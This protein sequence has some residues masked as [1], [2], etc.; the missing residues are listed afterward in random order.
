MLPV[1]AMLVDFDGTAC[2]HDAAEHLLV[3][4]AAPSW[5]ELDTAWE[6]G[7]LDSRRVISGQGAMLNAPLERLIAFALEHCP[8]DPTFPPFVRWLQGE[9]VPVT[10]V[11]DGFGFY[12]QP[13]L[14]A[15]GIEGIEVITNTWS[16]DGE[17]RI[18]FENGHA[19][20]IGCGTCKM[21]AVL[22]KPGPVAFVGEGMSDRYA[23][24]YSDLVFAKDALVDIAAAD[25]VPIVSWETFDH[26]RAHLETLDAVPLRVGPERCPGWRTA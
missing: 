7:E 15:A 19:V 20:C 26:V 13:L 3:E 5:R 14:E 8:I 17:E 1:G 10:I 12:I 16:S 23:A 9:N 21:N 22:S 25:G 24:I 18:R 2:S 11:S 4:F 6:G